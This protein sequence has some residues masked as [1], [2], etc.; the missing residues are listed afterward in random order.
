MHFF[1]PLWL[2]IGLLAATL[3]SVHVLAQTTAELSDGEIRKVDK[4]A[5]KITIQHGVIKSLDMPAMT[6]VFTVKNAALLEQ[7]KP[8]DKVKFNVAREEGKLVLTEAIAAQ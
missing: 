8:G 2:S 3:A 4:D 1:K 7:L 5:S 6:M